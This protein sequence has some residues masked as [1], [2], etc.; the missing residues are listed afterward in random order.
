MDEKHRYLVTMRWYVETDE[1]LVPGAKETDAK[2]LHILR[3]KADGRPACEACPTRHQEGHGILDYHDFMGNKPVY[4]T[5]DK[6]KK[7]PETE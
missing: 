2:I 1:E 4:M 7:Q 5:V 3:H 6:I